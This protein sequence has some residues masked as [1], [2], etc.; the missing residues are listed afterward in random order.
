MEAYCQLATGRNV[1]LK[2]NY[3]SLQYY[4]RNLSPPMNI[5]CKK[6]YMQA[7]IFS[8][9][10][11]DVAIKVQ[12]CHMTIIQYI[13]KLYKKT[14]QQY[15]AIYESVSSIRYFQTVRPLIMIWNRYSLRRIYHFLKN[16]CTLCTYLLQYYI[17]LQYIHYTYHTCYIDLGLSRHCHED[18]NCRNNTHDVRRTMG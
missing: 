5:K 14:Y 9:L 10:D 8:I 2:F 7:R 6:Y 17:S 13:Q 18:N 11:L 1:S 4:S 3:T 12:S 15:D 16:L